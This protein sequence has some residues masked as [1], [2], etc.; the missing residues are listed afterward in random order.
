A[1]IGSI[2]GSLAAKL[3]SGIGPV[4]LLMIAAAVF[5][6]VLP[7]FFFME[8][9]ASGRTIVAEAPK[10]D[11]APAPTKGIIRTIFS[12]P[13]LIFLTALVALERFVPDVTNLLY[14]RTMA[15]AFGANQNALTE[16]YA[17]VNL[18]S[19]IVTFAV[20]CLGAPILR[21]IGV[22]G[23]LMLAAVLNLALF[24]LYP[25]FPSVWLIAVFYGLEGVA[26]YSLF[27]SAK[28]A[29]YSSTDH[30]TIYRVK[31]WI[32]MVV[33]RGARGVAGALLLV[34]GLKG[35]PYLGIAAAL[36]WIYVCWRFGREHE[37]LETSRKPA[38]DKKD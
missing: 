24:V 9:R 38:P 2:V 32:E 27:R 10:T 35:A 11:A 7:L 21:K 22:G 26:R 12:S 19:G 13:F 5:L 33:Y 14:K 16:M 4:P 31:G 20:G 23:S 29:A 18:V 3:L 8:R 17:N 6:P 36:A 34:V 15:S 30:D 37:K 28:E 25:F 1:A